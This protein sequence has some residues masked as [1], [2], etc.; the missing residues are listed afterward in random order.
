MSADCPQTVRDK[1]RVE[2]SRVEKSREEEKDRSLSPKTGERDK[3]AEPTRQLPTPVEKIRE[4]WNDTCLSLPKVREI[5]GKRQK[6]LGARWKDHPALDWWSDYFDRIQASSFLT[7]KNDRGWK[8]KFDWVIEPANMNKVLEGN[9]D[10]KPKEVKPHEL[11]AEDYL[12]GF[13]S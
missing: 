10:E 4:L 6:M 3:S 12:R 11:T 1:S 5:V 8:A 2:K 9:Y 7:G 13:S